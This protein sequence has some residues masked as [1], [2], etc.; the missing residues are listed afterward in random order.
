MKKLTLAMFLS[1]VICF[2]ASFVSN[3]NQISLMTDK[4]VRLHVIANSNSDFDQS[5]KLK[6]R[7]SVLAE[8][9][10][11]LGACQDKESAVSVIKSNLD[12]LTVAA[13]TALKD[14]PYTA[15]CTLE[16]TAFNTRNYGDFTLP[17]GEYDALCVK[18]GASLGKNWWCVCYPDICLSACTKIDECDILTQEELVILKTPKKVRYK[19][20]CFEL[21]NKLKAFFFR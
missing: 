10:S 2:L 20:F 5:V 1:L 9:D 21:F 14:C 8:A 12:R 3:A 4:F 16:K 17:A 6:V 18:I 13:N 19:L 15:V 11:L 7:D